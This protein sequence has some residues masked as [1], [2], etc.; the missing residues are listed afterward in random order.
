MK[1]NPF[2]GFR[3]TLA[4]KNELAAVDKNFQLSLIDKIVYA[5]F[6]KPTLNDGQIKILK[7]IRNTEFK[8]TISKNN[9]K[10]SFN[11]RHLTS[12]QT[13]KAFKKCINEQMSVNAAIKKV[14]DA[15]SL[16]ICH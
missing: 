4:A 8:Y 13:I 10:K 15:T 14:L 12:Q 9:E 5:I 7:D 16:T 6:F 11:K 3:L 1:L 2:S